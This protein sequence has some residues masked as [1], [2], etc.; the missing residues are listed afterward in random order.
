MDTEL[1]K[2]IFQVVQFMATCGIGIFVYLSNKD[3]VTND[4]IGKLED[5]LDDKI[6]GHV[7]RIVALETRVKSSVS[8]NDLADI[9]NKINKIGTDISSLSG[10]FTGVSNL[11]NTLHSYLL[12]GAQK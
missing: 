7:E 4:R 8:H 3:K 12:N 5:D 1:M 6:D 11:L 10:E 9:H 2:L